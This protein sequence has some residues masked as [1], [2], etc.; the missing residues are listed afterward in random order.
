M[1]TL[2]DSQTG[3]RAKILPGFGFNCFSFCPRPAGEPVEVLWSVPGFES[4]REKPSRSGIPLLFPFAGRINN[5]ELTYNGRTYAIAD[6][7]DANEKPIHGFV[8]ARP[9]R[10]CEQSATRVVGEFQASRVDP[11]LLKKWPSD[12]RLTVSYE[13][14]GNAL[15][16]DIT[17]RNPGDVPLPFG[18]GTHPYF[19]VPLGPS[20]KADDCRITAPVGEYWL[21][22]DLVPTGERVP[23]DGRYALSHG[24]TF[25]ETRFDDV[26]TTLLPAEGTKCATVEDPHTGRKLSLEFGP[27]FQNLVVYNPPHREAICLEPYSCVPDPFALVARG[28]NTGL[29]ELQP[30]ESISTRIVIRL[31]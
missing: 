10:V 21:L 13:L 7:V 19:R 18:L 4:G 1:I 28:I 25:A 31:D 20:G 17:V 15:V 24:L 26:F 3:S 5:S 16:S 9:W 27:L 6:T 8:I 2:D 29:Q 11:S 12:F 30:G 23:A 22:K 14:Q